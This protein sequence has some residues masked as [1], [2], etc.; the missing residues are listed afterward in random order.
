MKAL[1]RLRKCA[2]WSG[3]SLSAYS[4]R[5]IFPCS[6]QK[7]NTKQ[8][9]NVHQI[10]LR[11]FY[12]VD[13]DQNKSSLIWVYTVCH[14][15]SI[16]VAPDQKIKSTSDFFNPLKTEYLPQYLLEE[17]IFD[18]MYVRLYYIFLKK[19]SWPISS[20]DLIRYC[21]YFKRKMVEYLQTVET[22]IEQHLIWV[23][24]VCHLP[25]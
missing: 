13:L 10:H 20:E 25:I 16:F 4:Q 24:T 11:Y 1:I 15:A 21:I 2:V 5:H 14:L 7:V 19:N 18:F 23:C 22:L 12:S 8:S 6:S 3:L 9:Q 17:P